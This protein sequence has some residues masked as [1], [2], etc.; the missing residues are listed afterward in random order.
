MSQ[1]GNGYNGTYTA[2]QF[3]DAIPGTGGII[4]SIAN[5]VGCAWHTAKKWIVSKPTVQ[6]AYQDERNKVLDEAEI[7]VIEAIR[8]RD[9]GTVRWYLSTVGKDRGYVE[10]R[11][12]T[13]KGGAPIE[14]KAKVTFDVRKFTDAELEALA[15]IAGRVGEDPEGAPEA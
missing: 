6:Q 11:E 10:R 2:Q 12:T 15:D 5:K 14:H 8:A 1:N 3:I 9:M 13:G 7:A 4:R